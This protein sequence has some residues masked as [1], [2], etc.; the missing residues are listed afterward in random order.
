MLSEGKVVP[1][2]D[3]RRLMT[4][5][6]RTAQT[7]AEQDQVQVGHERLLPRNLLKGKQRK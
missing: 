6:R 1:T 5:W 2:L 7:E 3:E 4:L